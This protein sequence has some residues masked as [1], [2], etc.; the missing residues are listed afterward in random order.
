[1]FF[2]E[3][4]RLMNF[5][6]IVGVPYAAIPI[7]SVISYKYNRPMVFVRKEQK[8][9]GKKKLIE[10]KYHN[11]QTAVLLDDVISDGAS[12]LE[13][14][15]HLQQAGLRVKDV[16][17]LL[18][19]SRKGK[20]LTLKNGPNL[21]YIYNIFEVLKILHNHKMITKDEEKQSHE[22]LSRLAKEK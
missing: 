5:D 13:T 11:G 6:L 16:V 22:F 2:W 12:K 7:A 17:V 15:E 3:E 1:M 10:G 19:R 21:T 20:V 18:D 4:L 9:Y 14:I 8:F